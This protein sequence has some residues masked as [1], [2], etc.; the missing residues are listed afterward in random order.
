M[1]VQLFQ[2]KSVRNFPSWLKR[3]RARSE[4]PRAHVDSWPNAFA[5]V[6]HFITPVSI[7]PKEKPLKIRSGKI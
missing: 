3:L 2:P 4:N 7:T 5:K 1:L 6:R